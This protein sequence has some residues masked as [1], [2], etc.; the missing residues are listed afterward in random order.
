M[1]GTWSTVP[2]GGR[3]ADV[4]DPAGPGPRFALLHLH[5]VTLETLRGRTAFS[6]WFDELRLACVCP[7]GGP[8]WWADRICPAFD[9][10]QTPERYLLDAV[11]PFIHDR[12]KSRQGDIGLQG[13]GM[14]GQG[15]LRL[16]FKHPERFL[17]VA[18]IAPALDYHE[19][20]GQGTPLD[21]MYDSKEQ[22]RQDT[23]LLHVHPSRYPAHIFFCIDPADVPWLRGNDRLHEKLNA[24]GIAHETDFTTSQG[25]HTWDYFNYMAERVERFVLAGLEQ[26]SRRLL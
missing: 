20:Y 23:A 21:Q 9:P 25:G 12:W 4:Y 7:H 2:I 16:A 13:I 3:P 6:R 10:A 11:V 19:R 8:C 24:L 22:C 5:D 17:T 15:A 26:E 18:A 14:G 1:S